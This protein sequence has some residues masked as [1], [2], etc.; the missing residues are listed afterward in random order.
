[1]TSNYAYDEIV[2]KIEEKQKQILDRGTHVNNDGTITRDS[3]ALA[4]VDALEWVLDL[5][6]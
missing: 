4:M 2:Q 3:H 1:M 5:I 6:R